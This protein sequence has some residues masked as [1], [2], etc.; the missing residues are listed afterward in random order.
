MV[1]ADKRVLVST[2]S[3][4]LRYEE[5]VTHVNTNFQKKNIIPIYVVSGVFM[6]EEMEINTPR[7]FFRAICMLSKYIKLLNIV[8]IF[9]A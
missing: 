3:N 8:S 7:T 4:G 1:K 2:S 9:T 6:G 5:I